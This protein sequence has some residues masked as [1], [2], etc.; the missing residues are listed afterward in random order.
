MKEDIRER[1]GRL[2][3]AYVLFASYL[4]LSINS[5]R[6]CLFLKQVVCGHGR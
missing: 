3:G 4:Y 2:L 6:K 5:I 1:F